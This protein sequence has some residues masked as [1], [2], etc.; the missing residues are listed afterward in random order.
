MKLE[1]ILICCTV[2]HTQQYI[3]ISFSSLLIIMG[4]KTMVWS[5]R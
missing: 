1:E 5:L 4:Q 2:E 3:K